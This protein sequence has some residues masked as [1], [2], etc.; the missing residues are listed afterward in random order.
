M[1]NTM[2]W[3]SLRGV[4]PLL[5]SALLLAGCASNPANPDDPLER[6]NR[7]MFSF[8]EGVDRA[9]VRPVAQAYD[10]VTP[11]LV[12]TGV[13]NFFGNLEDV[14]IGFNNLLQ[15]KVGDGLSDWMRFAVN[16]TFGLFGVLDIASEAGLQKN[17][18]D[19]GQT[20]AV[21]GVGEGP[22]VVLPFLGPRTTR[23]AAALPVDGY[24]SPYAHINDVPVRN[25][26]IALR[27]IHARAGLLPFDRTVEEASTD[28]YAFVRD[29]YLQ[30]RRYKVHDG[31]VP[32]EYE[33]YDLDYDDEMSGLFYESEAD[34]VAKSA[35]GRLD[36]LALR[37]EGGP[38]R[39]FP[40][41]HR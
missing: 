30:Q 29:F 33:D 7:A 6:Y 3:W 1:N 24:G 22:Y 39:H 27:L 23:D 17:D 10:T 2:R 36:L 14:W 19:F 34:L 28:K 13:G 41:A 16:T 15:G 32:L 4:V 11:R 26:L 5:V 37:T 9:V 38:A 40:D 12:R 35:V 25:S 31:D 8:N 18:E 20:L 21:W